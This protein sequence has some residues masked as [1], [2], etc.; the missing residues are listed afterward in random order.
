M[1]PK[2]KAEETTECIGCEEEK[3]EA[4]TVKDGDGSSV[5]ICQDCWPN[6]IEVTFELTVP[7]A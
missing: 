6:E 3:T 5:S 7:E 4:I 1:N 2:I